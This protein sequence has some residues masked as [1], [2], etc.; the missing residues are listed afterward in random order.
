MV[1]KRSAVAAEGTYGHPG[2]P[3]PGWATD[4]PPLSLVLGLGQAAVRIRQAQQVLRQA[5]ELVL[6]ERLHQALQRGAA[7]LGL[8]KAPQQLEGL[9]VQPVA[10]V[11]IGQCETPPFAL[12][13]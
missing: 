10:L 8:H 4:R 1:D 2:A 9:L 6:L 13:T 11:F 12:L 3:N 5:G 7:A